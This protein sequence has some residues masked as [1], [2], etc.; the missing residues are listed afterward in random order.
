MAAPLSSRSMSVACMI[1]TAP[2]PPDPRN[3]RLYY[4]FVLGYSSSLLA[5]PCLQMLILQAGLPMGLHQFSSRLEKR[6]QSPKTYFNIWS[7]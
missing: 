7:I 6:T 5:S 4:C 2:P 3:S 1:T